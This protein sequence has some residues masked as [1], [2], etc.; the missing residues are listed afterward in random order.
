MSQLI[1]SSH[2]RHVLSPLL[3]EKTLK[4]FKFLPMVYTGE[5]GLIQDYKDAIIPLHK[6]QIEI[7]NHCPTKELYKY[8]VTTN[9]HRRLIVEHK[10]KFKY[11]DIKILRESHRYR[12]VESII[13]KE[14]KIRKL[15]LNLARD[16]RL[17]REIMILPNSQ[18]KEWFTCLIDDLV[19]SRYKTTDFIT[20][21]NF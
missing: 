21:E 8:G 10:K 16:N 14:L 6:T 5:I 4:S 9:V 11:F 15:L 3:K 1:K 19:T 2:L 20:Y 18:D 13:T 12:E 7:I 17:Q